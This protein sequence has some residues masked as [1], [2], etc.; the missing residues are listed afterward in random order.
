MF[1]ARGNGQ[2]RHEGTPDAQS[3]EPGAKG[4]QSKR[5]NAEHCSKPGSGR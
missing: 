2:R 1:D 5:Y 3:L 4:G